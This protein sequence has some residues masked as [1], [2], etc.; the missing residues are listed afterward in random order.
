MPRR[1]ESPAEVDIPRESAA[2]RQAYEKSG[3]TV[4]DIAAA[5]GL[6]QATVHIAMRG[7]RYRDGVPHV[8]V[9]PDPTLVKVASVLR[10]GPQVLRAAGRG[11]AATLLEEVLEEAPDLGPDGEVRAA[12]ATAGRS[13]LARQVLAAF[14]LDELA[15]EIERRKRAE[16]DELNR[17]GRE[18]AAAD[19]R[20]DLGIP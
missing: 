12:A 2:L 11:R 10:V 16:L 17:E 6:S 4:A 8:A 5:T 3:L 13:A 18:D 14:T 9:P 15:E 1:T 19:L 7:F 20:A